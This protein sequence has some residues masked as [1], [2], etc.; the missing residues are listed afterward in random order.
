VLDSWVGYTGGEAAAPTYRTV[1]RGDGH[2]EALKLQFDPG[3]LSYA[4]LLQAFVDDPHVPTHC[5]ENA[6]YQ[7]AIWAQN[8]EQA[9]VAR[10]VVA[11]SG[12]SIPVL[13]RSEWHDAEE[14]HQHF[15]KADDED[16]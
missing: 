6:Q 3:V 7:T 4:A 12:K 15:I 16:D 2:T 9:E 14:Y 13:P 5:R 10:R 11:H 1:C 8:E